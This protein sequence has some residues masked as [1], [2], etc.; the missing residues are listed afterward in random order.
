MA[1]LFLQYRVKEAEIYEQQICDLWV[2]YV[3]SFCDNSFDDLKWHYAP[4]RD[5][6]MCKVES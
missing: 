3:F 2:Q 4:F 1:I 6:N 5:N